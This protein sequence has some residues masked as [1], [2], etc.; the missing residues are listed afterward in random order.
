M[1]I[2]TKVLDRRVAVLDLSGRLD[3]ESANTLRESVAAVLATGA[4]QVVLN[5]IGVTD[6]DAAGLG[7]L[8]HSLNSVRAAGG[9]LRLVV[10]SPSVQELLARTHLLEVF[11]VDADISS[12]EPFVVPGEYAL[13]QQP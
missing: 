10:R 12:L 9:E 5:L 2:G 8:A 13:A 6:L 1:T 11:T 7:E 3:V 4:R